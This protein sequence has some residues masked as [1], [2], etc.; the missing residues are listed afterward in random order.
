ML[1]V[2]VPL[3][4]LVERIN[5]MFLLQSFPEGPSLLCSRNA[6]RL[7]SARRDSSTKGQIQLTAAR[8][9]ND[10]HEIALLGIAPGICHPA[11]GVEG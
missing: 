6:A 4:G 8:L 1:K 9:R 7:K 10:V 3:P 5:Q 11:E 2:R